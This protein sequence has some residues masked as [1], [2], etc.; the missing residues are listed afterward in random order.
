MAPHPDTGGTSKA[1]N[2][3]A[4]IVKWLIA[5]GVM[6]F[7]MTLAFLVLGRVNPIAAIKLIGRSDC[8]WGETLSARD[9]AHRFKSSLARIES[10]RRM[11]RRDGDLQLWDIPGAQAFWV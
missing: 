2:R 8:S 6:F 5:A 10:G 3:V 7:I 4:M 9:Y 1:G 11:I